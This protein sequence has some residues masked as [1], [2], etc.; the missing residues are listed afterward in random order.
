[1]NELSLERTIDAPIAKVWDIA[2]D[3]A[4]VDIYHPMVE[5]S[6]CLSKL[7]RGVGAIRRCDFYGGKEF[8]EE[9]VTS[10]DEGKSFALAITKGTLPFKSAEAVTTFEEAGPRKTIVRISMRYKMKGGPIGA[11][12]G[13]VFVSPMMKKMLG[14]V[15]EGL[16]THCRTGNRIGKN[17]V[18]VAG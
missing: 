14:R 9:A 4:R 12:F 17:G 6:R 18:V 1:M 13:A 2:S 7:Q 11:A 10:W 3:I 16:D 15:L 5:K 8:V